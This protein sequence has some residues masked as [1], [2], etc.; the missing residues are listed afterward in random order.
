[1]ILGIPDC[2]HYQIV[3]FVGS[4]KLTMNFKFASDMNVKFASD[5]SLLETDHHSPVQN[6][7]PLQAVPLLS[8]LHLTCLC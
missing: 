4:S 1:M 8:S 3:N 2:G 7:F 6:I 5:A